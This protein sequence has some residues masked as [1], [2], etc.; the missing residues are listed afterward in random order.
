MRGIT[1]F[2]GAAVSRPLTVLACWA[3]LGALLVFLAPA[4]AKSLFKTS[5]GR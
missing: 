2:D 4:A 5:D 1:F 3:V